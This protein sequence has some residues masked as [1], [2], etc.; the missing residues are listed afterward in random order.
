MK[1]NMIPWMFIWGKKI[2]FLFLFSLVISEEKM[3]RF[4]GIFNDTN[5]KFEK[6]DKFKIGQIFLHII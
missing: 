2:K 3:V 4:M 5:Q 6:G 1:L